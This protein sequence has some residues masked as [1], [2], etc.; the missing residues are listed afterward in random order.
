MTPDQLRGRVQGLVYL[1]VIGSP[2]LGQAQLGAVASFLSVPG[3]LILGGI[4]GM[5]AVGVMSKRIYHL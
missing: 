3:A 5:A 2:S 4:I 1:F